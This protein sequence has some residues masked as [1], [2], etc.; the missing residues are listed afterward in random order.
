MGEK[1]TVNE[2]GRFSAAIT[3]TELNE[4]VKGLIDRTSPLYD[5]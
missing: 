5:V 1:P 3:V 4:F 2:V